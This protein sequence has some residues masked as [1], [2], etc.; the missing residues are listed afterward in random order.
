MSYSQDIKNEL[1]NLD[2]KMKN[3]CC[4]SYLY[5][6]QFNASET[7]EYLCVYSTNVK[8]KRPLNLLRLR[9]FQG[10]EMLSR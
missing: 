6:F 10:R 2:P 3:C 9:R 4:F 7:D 8:T 1:L 5:G